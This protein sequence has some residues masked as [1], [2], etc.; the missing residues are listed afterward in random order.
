MVTGKEKRKGQR[1]IDDD[2]PEPEDGVRS[3]AA[4]VDF[5]AFYLCAESGLG[6]VGVGIHEQ[7]CQSRS[8]DDGEQIWIRERVQ[9]VEGVG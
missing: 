9:V 3:A 4:V 6:T 8:R 1:T 5:L 2:L 7:Q